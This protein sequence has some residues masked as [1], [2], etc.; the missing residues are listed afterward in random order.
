MKCRLGEQYF[1]EMQLAVLAINYQFKKVGLSSTLHF[2]SL[3]LPT[4]MV[5]KRKFRLLTMLVPWWN[6]VLKIN[7]QQSDSATKNILLLTIEL[8]KWE[9]STIDSTQE[10]HMYRDSRK[11]NAFKQKE[12]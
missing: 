1:C 8:T 7:R 5:N 2:C 9:K 4:F 3:S 11:E 10:Q 12:E 6:F